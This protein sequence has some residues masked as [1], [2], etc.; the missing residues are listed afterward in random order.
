M[1]PDLKKSIFMTKKITVDEIL[2]IEQRFVDA[3]IG[4]RRRGGCN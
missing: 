3:A 4:R 2:D 1:H